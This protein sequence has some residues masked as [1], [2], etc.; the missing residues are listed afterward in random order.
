MINYKDDYHRFSNKLE[1]YSIYFEIISHSKVPQKGDPDRGLVAILSETKVAKMRA[2][3]INFEFQ[4]YLKFI[5]F[6]IYFI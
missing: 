3:V 5:L 2:E 1:M 4:N 6:K